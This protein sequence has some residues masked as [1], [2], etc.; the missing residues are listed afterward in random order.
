MM[1]VV[2]VVLITI[3]PELVT[4]LPDQVMQKEIK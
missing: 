3:W 2:A 1:M 4:W